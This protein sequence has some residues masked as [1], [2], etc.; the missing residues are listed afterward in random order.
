MDLFLNEFGR[1]IKNLRKSKGYSQEKLAELIGVSTNS[2]SAWE[3]GHSFIKKSSLKKLCNALGITESDLLD[4]S[5]NYI[6]ANESS[7]I[8]EIVNKLKNLSKE[9]QI[10]ILHIIET[11]KQ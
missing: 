2:V 10:Q 3:N 1:K 7:Y 5:D 8:F 9:Q 11:F 6:N 4:T